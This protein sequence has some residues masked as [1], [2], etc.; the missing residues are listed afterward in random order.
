VRK[1][2]TNYKKF[3]NNS[4]ACMGD[5]ITLNF[6]WGTQA[7]QYYSAVLQDSLQGLGCTVQ[8]RNF[9]V[10]GT[11]TTNMLARFGAMTQYDIPK[12]AVIYGGINDPGNAISSATTTSNIQ[13]MAQNMLSKGSKVIIC[14]RHY[15]NYSIGGDSTS[16]PSGTVWQAEKQAYDNL[17]GA[18]AGKVA[19][20]DFYVY[21]RNLINAGTV[22]QGDWEAWHVADQNVHLNANGEKTLADAL[23]ATIQTQSGWIDLLK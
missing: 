10:S 6:I 7:Y 11:T 5:S 22:T 23:L 9:G 20:C 18:N 3:N 17:I 2:Q 15:N 8:C 12:I 21:M 14:G 1:I 19:F 13:S 16:T 4:I